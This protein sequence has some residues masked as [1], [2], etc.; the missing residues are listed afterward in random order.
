MADVR[1]PS[2]DEPVPWQ[3]TLFDDIFLLLTIGLAV[4]TVVYLLWGLMELA[5]VPPFVPAPPA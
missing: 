2:P 1:P 4:P 3:Q 5:S